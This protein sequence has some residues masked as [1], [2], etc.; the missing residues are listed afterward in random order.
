MVWRAGVPGWVAALLA[1]LAPACGRIDFGAVG[2]RDGSASAACVPT[3]HDEDGD[4]ID[5]ACDDCPHLADPG[6]ADRDGDGVGDLCDPH[7][8][9]PIDRIAFFDPFTSRLPA[10]TFHGPVTYTGDAIAIAAKGGAWEAVLAGT[11]GN[12]VY[13]FGGHV[14][15]I[16][17][18]QQQIA[19]LIA[20]TFDDPSGYYCELFENGGDDELQLTYT[21]DNKSYFHDGASPEPSLSGADITLAT[22]HAPPQISCTADVAAAPGTAGGMIPS[23]IAANVGYLQVLDAAM[24]L[25]YF[26]QI[27]S[28]P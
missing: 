9:Q 13:T 17:T 25:D 6:Q 1:L 12:D 22:A 14:A 4:G 3:G 26:I 19:F 20:P 23:G 18:G 16:G 10:W 11:P 27:H 15:S 24:Q 28:G 21:Y 5:D 7:P 8:D 2:S